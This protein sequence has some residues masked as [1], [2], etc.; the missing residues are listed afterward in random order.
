MFENSVCHTYGV[1]IF[2]A[3][4]TQSHFALY[5]PVTCSQTLSMCRTHVTSEMI[6]FLQRVISFSL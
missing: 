1:I 6:A 5:V 4:N 3:S 2:E